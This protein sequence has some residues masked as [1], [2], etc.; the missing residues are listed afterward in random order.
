MSLVDKEYYV[1]DYAELSKR[2]NF[3][4][5]YNAIQ[6]AMLG[7]LILPMSAQDVIEEK[8]EYNELDQQL[9]TVAIKNFINRTTKK[10]DKLELTESISKNT[11][12]IDYSNFQPVGSKSFP[13][14]GVVN[15]FYHTAAGILNNTITIEYT[16]VEVGDKEL[17]FPFKIPKRYERR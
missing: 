12:Q 11:L 3:K 14:T 4:I 15:L 8:P 5:D 17:S 1:Y 7:N 9:Q 2:F 6:S 10:L 16:K 13:Y